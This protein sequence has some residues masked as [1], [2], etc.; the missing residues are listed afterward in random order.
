MERNGEDLGE[1]ETVIGIYFIFKS[2]F[3]VKKKKR[4]TKVSQSS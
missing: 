3:S 1:G 4:E 2:L